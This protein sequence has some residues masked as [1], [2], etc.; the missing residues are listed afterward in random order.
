[1][2]GRLDRIAYL[3]AVRQFD[4]ADHV[5]AILAD[6]MDQALEAAALHDPGRAAPRYAGSLGARFVEGSNLEAG[7]VRLIGISLAKDRPRVPNAASLASRLSK[8]YRQ[9]S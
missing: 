5:Y 9:S 4:G 1:M 3:I 8:P 6:T 7:E 2:R